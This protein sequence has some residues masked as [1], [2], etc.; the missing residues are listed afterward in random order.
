MKNVL[1]KLGVFQQMGHKM[2]DVKVRAREIKI[3]ES[4]GDKINGEN[5]GLWLLKRIRARR[6]ETGIEEQIQ[7]AL[8][9]NIVDIS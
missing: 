1:Q 2:A 9:D 6:R 8:I 7:T 3:E 5:L 4:E